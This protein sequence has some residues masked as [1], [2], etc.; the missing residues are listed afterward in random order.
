M[1]DKKTST[2]TIH[3][4]R[5]KPDEWTAKDVLAFA[6]FVRTGDLRY[7]AALSRLGVQLI[8]S[9]HHVPTGGTLQEV[10]WASAAD[11]DIF[12]ICDG[13]VFDDLIEVA[14]DEEIT[15]V[16]RI[17]RGPTEYAVRY[18]IGDGEGNFDGYE[19]ELKATREEAEAYL[20]D[21]PDESRAP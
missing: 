13:G 3:H 21:V 19:Y 1:A 2:F 16:C 18:A 4:D 9:D 12:P 14:D 11:E 10:G 20:Q 6:S 15:A 8:L 5:C 17:Y 7:A